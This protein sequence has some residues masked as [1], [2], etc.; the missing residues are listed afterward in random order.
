MGL[1]VSGDMQ[2]TEEIDESMQ[3]SLWVLL[4]LAMSYDS[5]TI[6]KQDDKYTLIYV[7]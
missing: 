2:T 3:F 1:K 4:L 6:R 7:F 5:G